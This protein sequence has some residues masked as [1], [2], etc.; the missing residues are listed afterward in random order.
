MTDD[1]GTKSIS[2]MG[3]ISVK[4][5]GNCGAVPKVSDFNLTAGWAGTYAGVQASVL[6]LESA[7]GCSW[8]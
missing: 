4:G 8:G 2:L 6:Q 7:L 3:F 5:I 1:Y